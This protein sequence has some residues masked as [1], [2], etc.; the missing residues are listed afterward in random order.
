MSQ[1]DKLIKK[2]KRNPSGIRYRELE[3]ILLY[4]ECEKVFAKGSHVKFK[5]KRL[6]RDIV[7]P[8]HSDECKSFYK[9]QAKKQIEKLLL[10][11][12]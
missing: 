2:F 1:I 6:M 7:I 9:Q 4:L 5:H 11:L 8:V 3:K 10:D 12:L